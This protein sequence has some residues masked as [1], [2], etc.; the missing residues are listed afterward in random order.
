MAFLGNFTNGQVL[1]SAEMNQLNGITYLYATSNVSMTTATNTT[2]TFAAGDVVTN[3]GSWF[4]DATDRITPNIAGVYAV[5]AMVNMSANAGAISYLTTLKNGATIVSKQT[6][7]LATAGANSA[8]ST[9]GVVS[10]NGSTDYL[11]AI[12]YQTSGGS[13]NAQARSFFVYLLR[14]T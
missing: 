10:M 14:K 11:N 3:P 6:S 7:N 4:V 9:F 8:L 2:L 5:G 1:T 12:A 13:I